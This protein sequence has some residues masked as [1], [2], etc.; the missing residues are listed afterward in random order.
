MTRLPMCMIVDD[1]APIINP[2]Y[3]FRLQV[4]KMAEPKQQSGE[5]MPSKI[6]LELLERFA[7][8]AARFGVKGKFSILAYPAGLGSILDG[9]EGADKKELEAWL[10][11]ARERVEPLFDI[12]PEIMTHTLALD[13]DT[14]KLLPLS[15]HEWSQQQNEETLTRYITASLDILS[16]A[17]FDATGV[18]SPCDFGTK[19]EDAYARA[20]LGAERK[21]HGRSLT[22]Y[23]LHTDT[24][25]KGKPSHVFARDCTG[26]TVVSVVSKCGD[27]AWQTME[28]PDTS[29]DYV[30]SVADKYVTEDG[31]SGQLAALLNAG[32]PIVFHTHWQ[33]LYS[34]GRFT[35]MKAI[36][37]M[38][39]RVAGLWGSKVAWMKCSAFAERIAKSNG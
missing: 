37:I 13:L 39:E 6:P 17:G 4:G 28:S 2:L 9:W 11:V 19:V 24:Q 18:T 35:G 14:K 25:P 30:R 31:T 32:V 5:A 34:N 29:D 16:R 26:G 10:R 21:V 20:V 22:W 36:E 33:S 3:Y 27:F 38:F 12:T 7:E 15:E 8:A 1:P 23:F